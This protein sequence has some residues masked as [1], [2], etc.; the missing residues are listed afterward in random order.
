MLIA[1]LTKT[2]VPNPTN[3]SAVITHFSA[4]GISVVLFNRSNDTNYS[5]ARVN[6]SDVNIAYL[7]DSPSNLCGRRVCCAFRATFAWT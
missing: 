4:L 1:S 7:H 3:N 6:F 5:D 2:N